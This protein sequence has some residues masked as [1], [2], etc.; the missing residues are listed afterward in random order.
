MLI[1]EGLEKSYGPHKVLD[2]MDLSVLPGQ[3]VALLGPNGAGKSTFASI[4]A[5]LCR[6]D[7]GSVTLGGL[8][9][10]ENPFAARRHLGFVPQDIALY[11]SL[12]ARQNLHLYG[13]LMGLSGRTLRERARHVAGLL[14]IEALLDCPVRQLSGGQKRLVH[15]AP[16]ILHEPA[17]LL[18]D[19]P[20][21]GLDIPGRAHLL[22]VVRQL[23]ASGTAVLYSTHYLTEV[24][25]LDATVAILDGGRIVA[26][27]ALSTLIAA[28]GRSFLEL[29]FDGSAPSLPDAVTTSATTVRIPAEDPAHQLAG[30]LSGLNGSA[31]RLQSVEIIRPNLDAVY[32]A[33]TGK[34]F[35]ADHSSALEAAT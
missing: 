23:A 29:R 33:I 24:E 3:I 14:G 7:A 32:L 13:A 5:D 18:L 17:V 25:E 15:I 30:V 28:H 16:A 35:I 19:E 26:C 2:G 22:D 1:V 8:K 21:A 20:T 9:A 4:V 31:A 6:P 27:D 10:T 11:P 34:R 12:T